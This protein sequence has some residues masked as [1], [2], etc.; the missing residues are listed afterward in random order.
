MDAAPFR[1]D[2]DD[3]DDLEGVAGGAN[4]AVVD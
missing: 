4:S 3:D 1:E 2:D